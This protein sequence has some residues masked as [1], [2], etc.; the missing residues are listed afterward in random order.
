MSEEKKDKKKDKVTHIEAWY[1]SPV[2]WSLDD[3]E[4]E[5]EDAGISGLTTD[6]IKD[7]DIKYGECTITLKNG[8]VIDLGQ[9]D[10]GETDYKWPEEFKLFSEYWIELHWVEGEEE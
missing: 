4:D 6:D 10:F 3:Y 9:G 8:E 7:V 1:A 5:L 2:R